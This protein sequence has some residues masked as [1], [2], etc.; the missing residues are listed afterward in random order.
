M[1]MMMMMMI[2]IMIIIISPWVFF[3]LSVFFVLK[4]ALCNAVV[5][6]VICLFKVVQHCTDFFKTFLLV[7]CGCFQ[8]FWNCALYKPDKFT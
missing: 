2:M 3:R 1:M 7:G 6:R 4:F 8:T 5:L